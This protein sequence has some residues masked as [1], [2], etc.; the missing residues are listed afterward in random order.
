MELH[1]MGFS[2]SSVARH[3]KGWSRGVNHVIHDHAETA[4]EG[5]EDI[6]DSLLGRRGGSARKA[7]RKARKAS[8]RAHKA[9]RQQKRQTNKEKRQDLREAR[10]EA[11]LQPDDSGKASAD[12]TEDLQNRPQIV[13]QQIFKRMMIQRMM[14]H[15]ILQQMIQHRTIKL[16]KA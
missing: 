6:G 12:V 13:L 8:R 7:A 15:K 5:L 14:I 3:Q 1:G 10:K 2:E 16:M 9:T 11:K 4:I